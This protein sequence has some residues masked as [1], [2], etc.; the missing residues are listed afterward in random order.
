ME[1]AARDVHRV[2]NGSLLQLFRDVH[3]GSSQMEARLQP[4]QSPSDDQPRRDPD[5]ALD[6]FAPL[7]SIVFKG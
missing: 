3:G 7:S 4:A 5:A 2:T 6:I 1:E